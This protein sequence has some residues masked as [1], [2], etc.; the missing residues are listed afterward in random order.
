MANSDSPLVVLDDQSS[1][2]AVVLRIA[3]PARNSVTQHYPDL[4]QLSLRSI[5]DLDRKVAGKLALHQIR[6]V[7]QQITVQFSNDRTKTFESVAALSQSDLR[8]DAI[9]HLVSMRWSFVFDAGQEDE[10]HL[11]S[12]LVRVSERPNPGLF[13]QKVMRGH[14]DDI[15]DLDGPALAPIACKID[16]LEGRFSSELLALVTEWVGSLPRAEPTLG[17]ARWLRKHEDTITSFIYGTFPALAVLAALGVWMAYLPSWITT[18]SKHAV[19]W[20]LGSAVLFLLARY[21][22]HGINRVLDRHL[23]RI[24]SVPA[25]QLTAGDSNRM[26]RFLAKSQRSLYA[27]AAGGLVYGAFKA[28]GL[29]LTGELIRHLFA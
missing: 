20:T 27:L 9:T 6:H 8:I 7:H 14:V 19:A 29:Y 4:V 28:L 16:F 13:L 17:V 3:S 21:F 26:T 18:S 22:A 2:D 12:I 25:F 23:T 24:C 10:P 5:E 15:E 11:H 1:R